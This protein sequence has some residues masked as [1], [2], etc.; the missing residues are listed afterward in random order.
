MY[1]PELEI[2]DTTESN[3]SA[4]YLDLL[5]SFCRDGQL[6]TSL[7]DKRDDFNFHI[8]NFPFL[9]SNIPS[10]PAYGV[11]ISQ[12]IRYARACSSYE[13]FILR[14]M[15]LSKKLLGQ[16]YVKERLK[17]SLRKFYCRYADLTKQYEVPL[18]RMLHDIL[19]DDHIQ[20]HPPLIG[21]Y[22]NF[23]PL[24]IWTLWSTYAPAQMTKDQLL[25][26]HIN[27]LTKIDV[28]IDK[29]ELPTFYWLPKLHKR[30]YQSRFISNS[31]HCSTT[32]LSKHITSALTAVKDHIIKYSETAFSN[33]NVN[34]FCSIKNS[35][36]V[37]E[38]LRLRNFRCSHV[39]SFDF[40][41]VYTSLPHDLI[42]AKV[43]SLVNWCF[44]RE[45]KT[46]LCTSDKAGFF[47]NKKYDSYKCWS[48]AELWE[49]FT[50][51]MENIYVQFD[52]MV[53]QQ[54]V[55]IPMGTNCAPLITDLFLYCYERDFMSDLQ[56]S[57][58]FD[59][60]DMFN[61]TSRYL[62]D[63]FTIDNPEFEKHIPDI[64][65]AELQL[66][67]ANTSDKETSFLDLNIKVI[68]S[69]IH[70]SVYDKRDDF[71]F[72]I[73]N[74]PWLS[75]DVPRLPSSGIYISQLVRFAR[76]C[77]SV[78]DF[79]SKNLQ[80]TSK[81]L[82]Q[83][84]RYHKLRKTFEKFL[85]SYSELLSKFGDISFQEYLS[86]EISHPVF[87]GDLVYKLRRVKDTPIFILSGSKIVKRLRRPS[88]H[89]EDYRSCAW[90]FYS[91]VR[92]FPK[93]L[94]SD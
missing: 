56:K 32:I 61:D 87:Y 90:P 84:Y 34:Y 68:G 22:T 79:H 74:F 80:I 48:C 12:L 47:N 51:L 42:K 55:G 30:P 31:S 13:C 7:Y 3:T 39:S 62:D 71:G 10:S 45:S 14:A 26:H 17:S 49:A 16:G 28:K 6:R 41:T 60:I 52:G 54:I 38:K 92:T 89:R 19:D 20:W 37:I 36:E 70:T 29:C 23:W 40:S 83:G 91:R 82:T 67:K 33:S 94:H 44:T 73:V 4:S 66:N 5:L 2:K 46:Y 81:L 65:P 72:P 24:L 59:L 86:K 25:V 18:S 85:R 50:F 75:G 58:R 77:T 35:S 27:S 88:D 21:H 64:Y 53:Y 69:D 43:L 57:K 11:F 93:A 63:I 76:C 1:P 15:R 78:L 9:S 8:T